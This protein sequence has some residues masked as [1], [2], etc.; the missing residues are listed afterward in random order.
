M[1][2]PVAR[3]LRG[4]RR[5]ALRAFSS[6]AK[7]EPSGSRRAVLGLLVAGSG[8]LAAD[9]AFYNDSLG[10]RAYLTSGTGCARDCDVSYLGT[11]PRSRAGGLAEILEGLQSVMERQSLKE[12]VLEPSHLV[13]ALRAAEAQVSDFPKDLQD[14]ATAALSEARGRLKAAATVEDWRQAQKAL[15]SQLEAQEDADLQTFQAALQALRDATS[16]LATG[17]SEEELG[18]PEV[19][20][21][22]AEQ[23]LCEMQSALLRQEAGP[24]AAASGGAEGGR[25]VNPLDLLGP[26]PP[27]V[28]GGR[29]KRGDAG[30]PGTGRRRRE[31][32]RDSGRGGPV[33]LGANSSS[34][35]PKQPF[36][37]ERSPPIWGQ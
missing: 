36:P 12:A 9:A 2:R 7:S 5:G 17:L 26:P 22:A 18:L 32:K 25:H 31:G 19:D 21:A 23:R 20:V 14:R 27:A 35:R 30:G 29:V 6:E 3:L 1:A 11:G 37:A 28:H 16:R 33:V 24:Y 4:I 13:E 10:L 15:Q 34:E 8:A